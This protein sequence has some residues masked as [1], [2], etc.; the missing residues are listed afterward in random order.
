MTDPQ[1]T[2]VENALLRGALFLTANALKEYHDAPHFEIDDD[3]VPKMEVI[4][5]EMTRG[6]AAEA[7]LRANKLLRGVA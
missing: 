2:E 7:L 3:G 5:S 1:Q 6:K 4:V